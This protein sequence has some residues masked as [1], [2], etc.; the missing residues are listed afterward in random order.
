M[1]REVR[2]RFKQ[3]Y[4]RLL[5]YGKVGAFWGVSDGMAW[6]MCEVKNYWPKDP[7]IQNQIKKRASE[8]G[9]VV[10]RRKRDLWAMSS[11]ELLWR[12]QNREIV[13]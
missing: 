5:T 13:K 10:S 4:K 12:I 8:L 11:Q 1:R 9:I 7:K 6:N 3:D 2:R